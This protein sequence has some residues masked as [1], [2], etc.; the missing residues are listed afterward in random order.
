MKENKLKTYSVPF[1]QKT[2]HDLGADAKNPLA[3]MSDFDL[4][5]NFKGGDEASFIFIYKKYFPQL[6]QFGNQFT[7]KVELVEDSIQDLFIELREKREKI[8]IKSSIKF[9]LFK[10]LKRKVIVILE[11]NK[12]NISIEETPGYTEFQISY[13]MEKRLIDGQIEK[14]QRQRLSESMQN[15]TPRQREALYYFYYEDMS[16]SEIQELMNFKHIQATRNL[17]Y[18]ALKELKS[19]LTTIFYL[20]ISTLFQLS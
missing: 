4:W 12:K 2:L 11:K 6:F 7:S 20:I 14:E 1:I 10:S 19:S 16:Y 15:L 5:N 18:R 8:T 17:M 3:N 13:S 9:Y